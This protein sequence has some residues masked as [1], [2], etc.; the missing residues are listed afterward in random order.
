MEA[1]VPET[2]NPSRLTSRVL[3]GDPTAMAEVAGCYLA[4]L[5]GV[6]RCAC[7]DSASADDAVQDALVAAMTR[8]PRY[9]GEGSVE[10]WLA[11]MVVN[12]CRARRRGRKND[13]TWNLPLDEALPLRSAPADDCAAR[14]QL[15]QQLAAALETLTPSDRALFLAAEHEGHTA[16]ELAAA[17]GVAPTAIRARLTRIRRRLRRELDEVWRE[18]APT[19]Q[20]SPKLRT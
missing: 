14:A 16:P 17:S 11:A 20:R 12:A 6:A 15:L 4:S 1:V 8:L 19:P 10:A 7:V 2:C 18:L 5:R 9:R 13:P 3:A